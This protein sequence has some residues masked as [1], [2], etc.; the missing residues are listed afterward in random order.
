MNK[1][2]RWNRFCA[3]NGFTLIELL[4]VVL[5]IGILAAVAVPQYQ[6]AVEKSK[7]Y[8]EFPKLKTLAKAVQLCLL[9]QGDTAG[10]ADRNNLDV[11]IDDACPVISPYTRCVEK[12]A[13]LNNKTQE[14]DVR[15][16]YN[17]SGGGAAF[18][19]KIS[20]NNISSLMC[21]A[22]GS[23]SAPSQQ[24]LCPKFGFKLVDGQYILQ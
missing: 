14:V 2:A 21:S 1:N 8:S 13:I 10:C 5:I 4:V 6:K 16:E 18:F 11:E 19:Y 7:L 17:G 22:G 12:V 15:V 23:P 20:L 3:N 9:D 24:V